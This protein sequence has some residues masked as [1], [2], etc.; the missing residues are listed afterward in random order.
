MAHLEVRDG[1]AVV[2]EHNKCTIKCNIGDPRRADISCSYW[3]EAKNLFETGK[4]I[5][6]SCPKFSLT[7]APNPNKERG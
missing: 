7:Y 3:E 2:P 4:V 1:I 5:S 6:A